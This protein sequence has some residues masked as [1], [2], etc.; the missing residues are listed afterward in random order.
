VNWPSAPVGNQRAATHAAYGDVSSRAHELAEQ[1]L[2]AN[3]HLDARRD[4][5][6][7]VR[8]GALLA[9][10]E[11][12]HRWLAEQADDVFVDVD[13]GRPHAVLDRLDRWESAAAAAEHRLAIDPLTRWRLNLTHAAAYDLAR[14]MADDAERERRELTGGDLD[15]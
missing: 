14:A 2:A 9:R 1:T 10:I 3:G 11:R 12:V 6:A 5:P 8:Y 13:A 4:G 15:G 7:V